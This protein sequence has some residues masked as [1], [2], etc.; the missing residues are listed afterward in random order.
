MRSFL[1]L[2]T[3]FSNTLDVKIRKVKT[4]A[5]LS[6]WLFENKRKHGRGNTNSLEQGAS[7][8]KSKKMKGQEGEIGEISYGPV[9]QLNQDECYYMKVLFSRSSFGSSSIF[10]LQLNR[11]TE[12]KSCSGF[13]SPY[14]FVAVFPSSRF[15]I[16]KLPKQ[17]N[18]SY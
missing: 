8:K 4:C 17:L 11:K 18:P 16:R 14:N 13:K 7:I 1:S 5:C 9:N 3:T 12:R 6:F 15:G 2:S 10:K